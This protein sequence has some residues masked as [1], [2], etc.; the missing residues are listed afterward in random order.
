M[1]ELDEV[2][3]GPLSG[4]EELA[5]RWQAALSDREARA[6]ELIRAHPVASL[7]GAALVGCAIA[8]LVRDRE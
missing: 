5:L 6:R 7:V 1:H 4:T 3:E 8:R 2:D